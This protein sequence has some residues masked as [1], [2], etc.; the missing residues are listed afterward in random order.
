VD[1]RQIARADVSVRTGSGNV[2][3]SL[4]ADAA[5]TLEARTGSGRISTAQPITLQGRVRRNRVTGTVR[6]GGNNVYITTGSGSI[7][8]R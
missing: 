4:P 8:V 6:G 5:Y 7:D 3:L 2:A 1:V